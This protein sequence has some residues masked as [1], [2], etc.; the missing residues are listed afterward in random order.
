MAHA[1]ASASASSGL[2]TDPSMDLG[3]T[4]SISSAAPSAGPSA[5]P[6]TG[7]SGSAQA[8]ASASASTGP[9]TDP[10]M[11]P[12]EI[13]PIETTP[14]SW[15]SDCVDPE[16]ADAQ[17]WNCDCLAE[18]QWA[19][20]RLSSEA[21]SEPTCLRAQMCSHDRV[22]EHWKAAAGCFSGDLLE[23]QRLLAGTRRLE[24]RAGASPQGGWY[25]SGPHTAGQEL[26]MSRGQSLAGPWWLDKTALRALAW[27][28][29]TKWNHQQAM[30]LGGSAPVRWPKPGAPHG[31]PVAG[32][33]HAPPGGPRRSAECVS[34]EV[35]PGRLT[36]LTLCS[37]AAGAVEHDV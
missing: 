6:S 18:M 13:D 20:L 16:I 17:S 29:P 28:V 8:G 9:T 26:P 23:A 22:C 31:E 14:P 11:E 33:A 10:S 7:P 3:G 19:C 2:G 12:I 25:D 5:G 24:E 35:R 1:E 36:R 27:S 37:G 21:F 34:S 30:A 15:T 4:D 32:V